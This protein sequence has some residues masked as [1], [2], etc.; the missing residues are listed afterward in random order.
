VIEMERLD[1]VHP[2]LEG[3]I[4]DAALKAV[5]ALFIK[6]IIHSYTCMYS[7]EYTHDVYSY[8]LYFRAKTEVVLILKAWLSS[9]QN[10]LENCLERYSTSNILTLNMSQH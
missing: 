9:S 4:M 2:V 3:I 1:K 7:Q 8:T 10:V 6:V 5:D